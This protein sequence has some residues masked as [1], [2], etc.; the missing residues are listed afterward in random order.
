MHYTIPWFGV[1]EEALEMKN[2]SENVRP[3]DSGII[4]GRSVLQIHQEDI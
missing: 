2:H 1:E 3:D 4:R